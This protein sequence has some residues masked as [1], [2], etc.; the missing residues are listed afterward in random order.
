MLNLGKQLIVATSLLAASALAAQTLP[1]SPD[2]R[3][4]VKFKDMNGA[5]QSVRA[6]G[7]QP[8][9]EL[10]PQRVV[11][12]YLPEQALR[13]LMN[14]PNV[15]YVEVD[16]RRYL[17]GE[18]SPYGIAM[19]EAND[20]IFANSNAS[21]CTV[22]I[23]DSGYYRA[24][25]DLKDRASVTGTNDS[26]S[27]LWYEDSCG[28]GTHV[29]GTVAALKNS[30]GV[31]GV[32]GNASL[33][34][35][36]EKVFD[37]ADCAWSYSSSL[38]QALN[39][40][41]AAASG[42]KLVVSMSL[43][44]G[45]ASTTE[46]NAFATAY[47]EGVLSI[48][49]AGNDGSTRKSYP[50]SYDSVVSVAAVDSTGTVADFSQ[51]NDAVEVAAPG[52]GVLS[53]TPFKA[54][55]LTAGGSTYLGANIDGSARTD[56]TATLVDGG[57]CLTAGSWAGNVVLCQRGDISF[58]DKVNNVKNGGGVGTAI[59]NNV[60][61]A[62]TGTL[63]TTSTIPAISISLADGVA[64]K[65]AVNTTATIANSAGVGSGYEYYD[66]T[67]MATPHVSG[68][69][70]LVWSLNLTKTNAEIRD[71][72]QKTAEDRGTAGKDNSYG[73]GIV[74]AAAASKFLGGGGSDGGTPCTDG[75]G[76]GV[77]ASAG[78][79][80][81]ND[82]TIFPGAP[83]LC[84]GKD[85]DCDATADEGC[86]IDGGGN[87]GDV[88]PPVISEVTSAKAKGNKFSISWTTNE[89]SNSEVQLT[90]CGVYSDAAMVTS[91]SMSFSGSKNVRYEY[92]VSST[93]AAG[94]KSTAGPFYHQN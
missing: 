5:A 91:H 24:H 32:N 87:D 21:G 12:A 51:K 79:C 40:C 42:K 28:H 77:C 85:N 90:C 43:G 92:Y 31:V 78:D 56:A 89:A 54:S 46:N 3:Y 68:V 15:E 72:L 94:N 57:L 36:V 30:V 66:G 58:A 71:A 93:D 88:V 18:T 74:K 65:G 34:I 8:V 69:A 41:K 4:L 53:T 1:S 37:G 76:D 14:H 82:A 22:C 48:A 83:E 44:G 33:N 26:G 16:E 10:G 50:A 86:P 60:E 63:N 45:R 62:F 11:A 17:M 75:D 39:R 9:I 64:A 73:Y 84:D 70:A 7:G 52:V 67:S 6:Q 59:Y 61:G 49:A 13:G 19:V 35:H 29:A 27:G 23:I 25:E 80:N 47:N 81:D 38:V 20:S 2:N 55:T